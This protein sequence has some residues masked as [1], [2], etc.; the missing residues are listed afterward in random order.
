MPVER[1]KEEMKESAQKAKP[2]PASTTAKKQ[3]QSAGKK[4]AKK[5]VNA[6]KPSEEK[7]KKHN[8]TQKVS[9]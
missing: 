4:I 8:F 9:E 1:V 2:A 3:T 6:K 5:P 7:L